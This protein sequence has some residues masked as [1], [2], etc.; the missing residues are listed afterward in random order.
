M[1]SGFFS[2]N[3]E[4]GIEIKQFYQLLW[5]PTVAMHDSWW[6]KLG[7]QM[8]KKSAGQNIVLSQR[9][10]Q[11]VVQRLGI[12]DKPLS[13]AFTLDEQFLLK[14]KSRLPAILS[15]LGLYCLNCPDYL[16]LK[17]HRL[18]LESVLSEEQVQQA[19][20]LWPQR[21]TS[22]FKE[23][24]DD[25]KSEYLLEQ[26]QKISIALLDEELK[27]SSLWRCI[28]VTLP[29]VEVEMEPDDF[30]AQVTLLKETDLNLTR[31]LTRLERML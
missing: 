3:E 24:V 13:S 4:E 28:A 7:L 11:L 22:K 21:P 20:A 10:E 19:W 30:K 5:R 17:E 27:E 26:A 2:P 1:I 18:A 15:V 8:W 29:V 23:L 14:S 6:S 16:S 12:I 31:W 25:I 9:I